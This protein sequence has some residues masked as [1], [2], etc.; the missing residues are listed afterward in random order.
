MLITAML[1]L[2]IIGQTHHCERSEQPSSTIPR[3]RVEPSNKQ[4]QIDKLYVA[5][6]RGFRTADDMPSAFVVS[7]STALRLPLWINQSVLCIFVQ[8]KMEFV[9]LGLQ[10]WVL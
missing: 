3:R 1:E 2:P 4:L 5:N 8:K 9:G 10:I 6:N 7:L